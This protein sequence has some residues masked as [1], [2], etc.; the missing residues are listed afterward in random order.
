MYLAV[1][2]SVVHARDTSQ[3]I[4]VSRLATEGVYI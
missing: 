4:L 2:L 3:Q 1:N